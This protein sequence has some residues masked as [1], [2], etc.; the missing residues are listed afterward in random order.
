MHGALDAMLQNQDQLTA[1]QGK[2]D[3]IAGKAKSFYGDARSA[4]RQ[5]Q[6]EE[7]R[8]QCVG[9]AVC[10]FLFV[11]L[12]HG[13]LFGDDYDSYDLGNYR[14]HIPPSPPPPESGA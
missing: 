14:L 10:V 11:F 6:C 5:L 9:A 13:W 8:N 1:L 12:F 7:F 3:A 4:R 2:S